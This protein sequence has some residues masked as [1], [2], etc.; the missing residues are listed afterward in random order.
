M[1][2]KKGWSMTP[3]EGIRS[4]EGRGELDRSQMR[5]CQRKLSRQARKEQITFLKRRVEN[6]RIQ[7][8]MS[9]QEKQGAFSLQF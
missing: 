1:S 5:R 4:Q 9:V 7:K 6:E 8:Y 3:S 2:A